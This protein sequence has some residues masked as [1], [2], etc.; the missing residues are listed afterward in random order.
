MK[1]SLYLLSFALEDLM[2]GKK[3]LDDALLSA[4]RKT[5]MKVLDDHQIIRDF[6]RSKN[7]IVHNP[8]LT[9]KNQPDEIAANIRF[10]SDEVAD[11]FLIDCITE[12]CKNLIIKKEILKNLA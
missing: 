9:F 11:E 2:Q 7:L 8:K 3:S 10:I 1:T 12:E 5:G 4:T 6:L